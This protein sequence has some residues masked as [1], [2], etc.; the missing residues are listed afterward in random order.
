MFFIVAQ[1]FKNTQYS[2]YLW[3]YCLDLAEIWSQAILKELI[4]LTKQ[5]HGRN[6]MIDLFKSNNV[7]FL[8]DLESYIQMLF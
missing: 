6:L 7:A 2:L 4:F 3:N 8:V 1:Y 5:S